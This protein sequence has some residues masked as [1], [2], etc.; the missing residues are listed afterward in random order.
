MTEF[1][2]LEAEAI[3]CGLSI[4]KRTNAHYQ[5]AYGR[6]GWLWNVYPGNRR[7]YVDAP[8]REAGTPRL[9]L[10]ANWTLA[11]AVRA[12]IALRKELTGR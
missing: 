5:I 2:R 12:A 4:T 6:G 7:I 8:H 1:N 11:D 9:D 3:Q 10:P